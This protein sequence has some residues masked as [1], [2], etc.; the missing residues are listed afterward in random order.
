MPVPEYSPPERFVS[1]TASNRAADPP[2][3]ARA[4]ARS[5]TISAD[6]GNL[7]ALADDR[8]PFDRQQVPENHVG[9][10]DEHA[11]VDALRRPTP[12]PSD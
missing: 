11:V 8:R 4:P 1:R 3:R 5:V 7:E 2:R 9:A 6:E 10:D 12:P